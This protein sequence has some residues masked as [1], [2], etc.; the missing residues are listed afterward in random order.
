[1]SLNLLSANPV[2]VVSRGRANKL[3][4]A[5]GKRSRSNGKATH[6]AQQDEM[7]SLG[8]MMYR[9]NSYPCPRK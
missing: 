9:V 2:S 4:P 1:M 7:P 8:E 3:T 5:A 6:R